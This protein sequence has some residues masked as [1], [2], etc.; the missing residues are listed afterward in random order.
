MTN[1]TGGHRRGINISK[2][3]G[4]GKKREPLSKPQFE[5]S[6]LNLV[7]HSLLF[8]IDCSTAFSTSMK[9][10]PIF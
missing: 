4:I 5:A 3:E 7:L 9:T 8:M 1:N 2:G 10:L 6:F